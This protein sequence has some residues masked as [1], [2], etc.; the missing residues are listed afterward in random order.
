MMDYHTWGPCVWSIQVNWRDV[1]VMPRSKV[2]FIFC[3][4]TAPK[5]RMQSTAG[6]SPSP[7]AACVH[8]HDVLTWWNTVCH[9]GQWRSCQIDI[10]PAGLCFWWIRGLCAK[11]VKR[12]T[13]GLLKPFFFF[14]LVRYAVTVDGGAV[15]SKYH[16]NHSPVKLTDLLR[17]KNS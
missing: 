6:W 11:T 15:Q 17:A 1:I 5:W 12:L 9:R 7:T 16:C 2:C 10:V 4:P 8:V 3:H 13:L 14:F